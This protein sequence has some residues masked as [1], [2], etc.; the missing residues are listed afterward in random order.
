MLR[1]RYLCRVPHGRFRQGLRELGYVEGKN[2]VLCLDM[3]RETSIGSPNF[4]PIWCGSMSTVIVSSGPTVTRPAKAATST[5]P[6]I[7]AFDDDPVGRVRRQPCA[8]GRE[9]YWTVHPCSRK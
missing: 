3:P 9:H 8:T 7:M 1:I 6:I 5:I 4:W 2:I